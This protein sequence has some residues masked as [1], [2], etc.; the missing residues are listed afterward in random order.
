[1]SIVQIGPAAGKTKYSAG[2]LN[3]KPQIDGSNRHG[4][5]AADPPS[6]ADKLDRIAPVAQVDR[7]HD[8]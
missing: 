6:S 5:V 2:R 7:A 4:S 8:F 3:W 1:V